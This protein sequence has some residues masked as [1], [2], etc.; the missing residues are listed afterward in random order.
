M[1]IKRGRSRATR[2]IPAATHVCFLDKLILCVQT[3]HSYYSDI[4]LF[5][6]TN[7]CYYNKNVCMDQKLSIQLVYLQS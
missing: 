2:K 5:Y 3:V 7:K 6:E 4:Y 1:T